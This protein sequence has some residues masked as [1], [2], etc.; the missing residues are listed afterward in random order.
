MLQSRRACAA[1]LR[2]LPKSRA[3]VGRATIVLSSC[4][5]CAD[6]AEPNGYATVLAAGGAPLLKGHLNRVSG[7]AVVA[8]RRRGV[9]VC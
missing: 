9:C 7:R 3:R 4:R 1:A 2:A 8:V 5:A 6:K